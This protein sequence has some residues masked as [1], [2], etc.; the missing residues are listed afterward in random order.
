MSLLDGKGGGQFA[1]WQ[2]GDE[3][4]ALP[5]VYALATAG[6]CHIVLS[7]LDTYAES[8]ECTPRL[9]RPTSDTH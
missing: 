2:L 7:C 6:P 4:R 3:V 1:K 9:L 5:C 8:G